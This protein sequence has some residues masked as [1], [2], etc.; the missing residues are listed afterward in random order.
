[1]KLY[2]YLLEKYGYDEPIF[3]DQ[4]KE[5]LE[6]NPNT[7][8]QYFKRLA[9][10]G[11]IEKVQNGL[12]FIPKKQPLFGS[13]VLNVDRI[14]QR[15][16]LKNQNKVTGYITGTNFT[17]QLGLTSQT[18]A[19]TTVVTNNTSSIKREVTFYKN[20]VIIKKPRVLITNENY[21]LLQVLDLL[22][23]YDRFSEKSLEEGLSSIKR[24][25]NGITIG[26]EEL[27]SYMH[28]YP[29]KT[30]LKVYE[31]GLYDAITRR[32]V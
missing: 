3:T 12:Y 14:I 28:A 8:R 2:R 15:K 4:V 21:R 27:K 10:E 18:A 1:M 26:E 24:Y 13:P 17:N 11:K 5:D 23:D 16:F 19:V 29:V 6:M 9:D 30:K 7:V 20:K 22:N 31:S 32:G 25:L